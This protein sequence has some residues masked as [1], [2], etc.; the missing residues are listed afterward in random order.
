[1]S[2]VRMRFRTRQSLPAFP[3]NRAPQGRELLLTAA[4]KKRRHAKNAQQVSP[5]LVAQVNVANVKQ[6]SFALLVRHPQG[7]APQG[8]SAT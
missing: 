8:V 1:M 4:R 7:A 5:A 6:A 3:A 2:A